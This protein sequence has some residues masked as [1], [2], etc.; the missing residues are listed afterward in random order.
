MGRKELTG[1]GL[2]KHLPWDVR[3]G[4]LL[5]HPLFFLLGFQIL[6]SYWLL[7]F[8]VSPLCGDFLDTAVGLGACCPP[9]S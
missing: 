1:G 4:S 7:H 8:E 5:E 6:Y 2:G 9:Y 3:D